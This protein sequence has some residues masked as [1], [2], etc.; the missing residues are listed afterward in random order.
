MTKGK[1]TKV[2]MYGKS[3]SMNAQKTQD[4]RRIY[5]TKLSRVLGADKVLRCA[6]ETQKRVRMMEL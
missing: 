6:P 5:K 1:I 3:I 2:R 4:V